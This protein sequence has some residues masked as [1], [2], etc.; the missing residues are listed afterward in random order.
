[1]KDGTPA[2]GELKVGF[3]AVL[4]RE[5]LGRVKLPERFE[6]TVTDLDVALLS[7]EERIDI[8]K[9]WKRFRKTLADRGYTIWESHD[10]SRAAR[11][12][13]CVKCPPHQKESNR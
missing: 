3:P 9:M 12:A 13:L 6:M 7:S 11:V 10:L 8:D 5:L 4:S 1:M 2:A